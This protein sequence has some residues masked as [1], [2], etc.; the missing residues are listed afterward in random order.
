METPTSLTTAEESSEILEPGKLKQKRMRQE[1][2]QELLDQFD[3]SGLP[4]MPLIVERCA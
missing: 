2:R 3:K 1:R 4:E